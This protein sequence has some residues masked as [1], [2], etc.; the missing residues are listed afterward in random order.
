[1]PTLHFHTPEGKTVL[2]SP[3]LGVLRPNHTQLI[4]EQL[5]KGRRCTDRVADPAN[6]MGEMVACGE[7]VRML[8]PQHAQPISKQF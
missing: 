7:G 6:P 2:C 8:G 1:M 5:G 4:G 3:S